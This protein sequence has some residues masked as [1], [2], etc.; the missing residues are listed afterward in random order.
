MLFFVNPRFV[1]IR[2]HQGNI[3]RK[4]KK[5]SKKKDF[6]IRIST[7]AHSGGYAYLLDLMYRDVLNEAN[8]YYGHFYQWII[9]S[10]VILFDICFDWYCVS[11]IQY[12]H[13]HPVCAYGMYIGECRDRKKKNSAYLFITKSSRGVGGNELV[14]TNNVNVTRSSKKT[15]YSFFL[16]FFCF[17][18]IVGPVG[19]KSRKGRYTLESLMPSSVPGRVGQHKKQ[20][21]GLFISNWFIGTIQ[22]TG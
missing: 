17:V 4:R 3:K 6:L 15:L 18:F 7:V 10:C 16:S 21:K 19:G 14:T 13:T 1:R 5:E 2:T 11:L 8:F 12:V 9:T 22:R 20:G